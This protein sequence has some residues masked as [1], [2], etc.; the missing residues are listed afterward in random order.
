MSERRRLAWHL[1]DDFARLP[2]AK[3]QEIE[4]WVRT[5][6]LSGHTDYRRFQA[7]A[8][9]QRFAI[10]FTERLDRPDAGELAPSP[11]L[12]DRLADPGHREVGRPLGATPPPGRWT[13]GPGA[14]WSSRP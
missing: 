11:P 5:A 2:L 13:K 6:I 9:K 4:A 3:R 12:E 8:M 14:C 10:Q 7:G 1:P